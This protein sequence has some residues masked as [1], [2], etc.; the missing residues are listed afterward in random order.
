MILFCFFPETSAADPQDGIDDYFI[1][2]YGSVTYCGAGHTLLTGRKR[3]NNDERRLF[4]N[5]IVNSAR[6][7]TAGPDLRLYDVDS[8]MSQ[9]DEAGN[10][11]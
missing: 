8:D 9:H 6:K 2:S 1:Y 10:R 7:S 11:Y 3:D 5:C 4:I